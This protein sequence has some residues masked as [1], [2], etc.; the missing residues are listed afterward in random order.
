MG[1]L[2]AQAGL[3]GKTNALAGGSLYTGSS[4]WRGMKTAQEER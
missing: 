1:D 3:S 4:E 2:R